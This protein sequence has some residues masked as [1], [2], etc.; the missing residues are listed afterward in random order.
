M[1]FKI[2]VKF[3]C[4]LNFFLRLP[5]E[6]LMRYCYCLFKLSFDI[7]YK[8]SMYLGNFVFYIY[9]CSALDAESERIV[10]EALDKVCKGQ[11]F[12]QVIQS[13]QDK[14]ILHVNCRC[15]DQRVYIGL[16]GHGMHSSQRQYFDFAVFTYQAVYN[17]IRHNMCAVLPRHVLFTYDWKQVMSW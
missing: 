12:R 1:G 9:F 11:Y 14:I 7:L 2:A 5:I 4:V 6:L 10:Q 8:Q 17:L 16:S 13:S 3:H 15:P